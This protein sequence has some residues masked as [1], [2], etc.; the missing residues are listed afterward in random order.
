MAK[1]NPI[2]GPFP[3]GDSR[4]ITLAQSPNSIE[5]ERTG[6]QEPGYRA[7]DAPSALMGDLPTDKRTGPRTQVSQTRRAPRGAAAQTSELGFGG[8]SAAVLGATLGT[9]EGSAHGDRSARV[10]ADAAR[11]LGAS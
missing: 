9:A 11:P 3:P 6:P 4:N 2:T 5:P 8:V 10:R 7:K 1:S